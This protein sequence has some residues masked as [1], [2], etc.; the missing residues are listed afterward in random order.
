MLHCAV[1]DR[2]GSAVE[3]LMLAAGRTLQVAD[4]HRCAAGLLNVV[5]D[6]M[7]AEHVQMIVTELGAIPASSVPVILREYRQE[8]PL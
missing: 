4:E 2:G 6:L 3:C 8:P 5:Y 7:P 1:Q